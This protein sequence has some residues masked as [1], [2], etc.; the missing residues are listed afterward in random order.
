MKKNSVW[1]ILQS[2]AAWNCI[3]KHL[4]CED[5]SNGFLTIKKKKKKKIGHFWYAQVVC[6]INCYSIGWQKRQ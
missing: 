4:Q 3:K 5:D 2:D 6:V 1:L